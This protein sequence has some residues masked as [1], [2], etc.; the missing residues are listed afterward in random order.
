MSDFEARL[1]EA[2][3][4]ASLFP[5]FLADRL[6]GLEVHLER[7]WRQRRSSPGQVPGMSGCRPFL[8]GPVVI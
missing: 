2:L 3:L 8:L 5:S 7:R 4:K 1:G 6:K